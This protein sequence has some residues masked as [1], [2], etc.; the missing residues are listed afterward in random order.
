M[1]AHGPPDLLGQAAEEQL[2]GVGADL[3]AEAAAH[4]GGDDA[5]V[6]GLEPVGGRSPCPRAVGVLGG[7][8]LDELAVVVHATAALRT[9]RGHGATR[10]LMA[11]PRTTTSQPSKKPSSV[12]PGMPSMAVPKTALL[13]ASGKMAAPSRAASMS[14]SAGSG[15]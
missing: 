1:P 6:V 3:G 4:V 10:W 2:L 12:T 13:P 14:M 9:S 8:P 5:H 15:S 11:R 7:Q